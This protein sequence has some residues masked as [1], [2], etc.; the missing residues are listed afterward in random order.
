MTTEATPGW[1]RD[2]VFYQIFPDRFASSRR[3]HKPGP[4][5]AWDA[6]PTVNGFKGGDLRGITEHL[7]HLAD[8]GVTAIY[9]NPIFSSASNHRY[10]TY[11]YLAVDPLLG[12]DAALRELLDEAHRRGMR[13]VLDGVFNHASRGFWPFH[14]VLET[15]GASPYRDW[16]NLNPEWLAAD[17]QL[18]A[19]PHEQVQGVP[20]PD[21]GEAHQQGDRSI[22]ELGYQAWWDLPALPKLNVSNPEVREYL[23]GV[24][25]HWIRFGADGWRLDVPE[26]IPDPAFW[27]EFR[28]RV[29]AVNPEA[30]ILGEIWTLAPD[31][32]GADGF[33]AVM[34]YPLAWRILG[35]AAGRHLDLSVVAEHGYIRHFLVPLDARQFADGLAEVSAAYPSETLMA[36]LNMLDS[37]DTPRALT[38]CGGNDTSLRL[39]MLLVMAMPGTPCIYYGDEI[40]MS[41]RVDPD[42]RRAFPWDESAWN[43]ELL[44]FVREAIRVRREHAAL[45]GAELTSVAVD[46][47]A[48]AIRRGSGPDAALVAVNAGDE[49]AELPLP[50][51]LA[52]GRPALLVGSQPGWEPAGDGGVVRLAPRSGVIWAPGR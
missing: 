28:R 36:Q 9:L 46:G 13:V 30:Y 26:E 4:L 45:R 12:G 15:G 18:R 24:A 21:W 17:R 47:S 11:D 6:P 1:V 27:A 2:A 3:V 7:D 37:H 51:D 8:L 52:G 44:S 10:H 33:D 22:H 40:G 23:L 41:G 39:A 43:H 14:H 25:E 29:R 20:D 34:N 48:V 32:V 31:W 19:Y 49:S 16:F 42:C 38:L 5:E 50:G 35:F